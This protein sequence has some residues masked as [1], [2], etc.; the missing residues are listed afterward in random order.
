M[1]KKKPL[2]IMYHFTKRE[3]VRVF[4]P[5]KPINGLDQV[6][7]APQFIPTGSLSLPH[8]KYDISRHFKIPLKLRRPN[9]VAQCNNSTT[10]HKKFKKYGMKS[11]FIG[12]GVWDNSPI[13][14]KRTSSKIW[15]H[16]DLLCGGILNFKSLLINNAGIA[17]DKIV[18]NALPQ[19]DVLYDR[20]KNTK[21]YRKVILGSS[22]YTKIIVLFGHNNSKKDFQ[23]NSIDF[24]ESAIRIAKIASDNGWLLVVKPKKET[25]I[26]F[27][28]AKASAGTPWATSL[29]GKFMALY[30]NKNVI[31]ESQFSDPYQYIAASDMVVVAGRSTIEIEACLANRPLIIV[32]TSDNEFAE[33]DSLGTITSGAATHVDN[34]E[35]LSTV[36]IDTAGSTNS[37]QMNK[38]DAFIKTLGLSFDG[39]HHI[40]VLRAMRKL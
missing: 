38:Q 4:E 15:H 3:H 32:R 13:N 9:I 28:Q 26:S 2:K 1:G 37:D 19:F 18:L 29:M 24:Y 21:K 40:R 22:S 36:I 33:Y 23:A 35:K 12:H 10:W 11:V 8:L 27:I 20:V 14:T 39:K 5:F 30:N 17:K 34:I 31:F 6:T 25:T 16:Y 7:C